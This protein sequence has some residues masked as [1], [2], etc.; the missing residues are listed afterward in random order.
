MALLIVDKDADV[1]LK[2]RFYSISHVD[3]LLINKPA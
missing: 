3:G 2:I 1:K